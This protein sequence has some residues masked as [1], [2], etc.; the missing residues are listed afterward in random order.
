M[1]TFIK[2]PLP[3]WMGEDTPEK[4]DRLRRAISGTEGLNPPI[5]CQLSRGIANPVKKNLDN[6]TEGD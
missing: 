5:H 2:A 3:T 6:I 1:K 4:R